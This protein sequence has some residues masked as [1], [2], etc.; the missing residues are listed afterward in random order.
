MYK[1][2]IDAMMALIQACYSERSIESVLGCVTDD[3]IWIGTEGGELSHGKK[4]LQELLKRDTAEFPQ[5]IDLEIGEPYIQQLSDTLVRITIEARQAAV[6]YKVCGFF[7]RGT[8]GCRRM[9]DGGWLIDYVH[10]SVPNAEDEKYT[11]SSELRDERNKQNMLLKG[12]PGGVA[13]YH[14]KNDGRVE[15]EYVSEGLAKICGYDTAQEF[16]MVLKDN[17][18]DNLVSEDV[19]AVME[20]VAK[21]IEQN[22]PIEISY[23]VYDKQHRPVLIRLNAN[24]IAHADKAEDDAAVLYAVHTKVSKE[25]EKIMLEQERCHAILNRLGIAYFEWDKENGFYTSE[26]Y[27]D[28]AVSQEG[29]MWILKNE[30]PT[31]VVHPEDISEIHKF[32]GA[33]E[34]HMG[35]SEVKL[36]CKMMDGSFRRTEIMGFYD[37]DAEGNVIR[38]LGVLRDVDKEWLEQNRSLQRALNEAENA[39]MAKTSFLSRMSHDMRTPLNG[40]L[41]LTTIMKEST[42]DQK[43]LDDLTELEL[44]GNYLLNLIND[45]LDVSKI[46]SGKMELHP[47]IC[48]GRKIFNSALGMAKTNM[49]NKNITFT[50]CA[51]NL[52]F[53]TLYV[54]KGRIEQVVMNILGN[55]IKFTP[56]GGKIELTMKNLYIKDG[57]IVDRLTVK[58]NGVGMSQ[59]FLSHIFE[60]FV[61]E[62]M[63]LTSSYE[64]TGLGMTITKQLLE[65]MG[66]SIKIESEQGKGTSVTFTLPLSIATEEQIIQHKKITALDQSHVELE[67]KRILLCEDHPLNARIAVR[68][69]TGR[70]AFVECARDGS[71]GV[72]M[73]EESAHNYYDA[74]LMD[75]RMPVMDG[76]EATKRIRALSR[77]DARFVPIIAMTANAFE[78]DVKQTKDAGMDAHLSKPV[79]VEELFSTLEELLSI[80]HDSRKQQVLV[81]DNV[82]A[83]RTLVRSAIEQDFEVLEAKDGNEALEILEKYRG[84]DVIIMDIQMSG[85]DGAELI[86]QVRSNPDYNHIVIIATTQFGDAEQEENLLAMGANDFVYKPT[87]LKIVEMRVRNALRRI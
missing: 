57:V 82:K 17:A 47:T 68:L 24:L 41:G 6:P 77:R 53:S 80:D 29:S 9:E 34:K 78:N 75:I 12:I 3:I 16:F 13:I 4:E 35:Q 26:R 36:R 86:R 65:L 21:G 1:R 28:Y 46:E 22:K 83:N 74:I 11:L 61:Q 79:R 63:S 2:H 62:N 81:V 40:I 19:P 5:G 42:S 43:I 87:T 49:R 23:R 37:Y 44:S 51:D 31:E 48:D 70:G 55:A 33:M 84:I 39:N 27:H 64:G 20:V 7:L 67:G 45:T 72:Q 73:F 56:E 10:V 30:S 50:V 58:D 25:E 85:M 52:P 14:V 60:P 38:M 32:F 76:L 54:D 8:I 18:T 71:E 66:G 59:E 15:T 69:L